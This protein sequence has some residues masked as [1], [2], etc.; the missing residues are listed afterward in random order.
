MKQRGMI[1]A[2]EAKNILGGTLILLVTIFMMAAVAVGTP[3]ESGLFYALI[4]ALVGGTI[5]GTEI[6]NF[7]RPGSPLKEIPDGEYTAV[8]DIISVGSRKMITINEFVFDGRIIGASI[9]EGDFLNQ[10]TLV[11]YNK[12]LEAREIK[13]GDKFRVN[14][15]FITK[16]PNDYDF[17]SSKN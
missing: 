17:T 9:G 6:K 14:G 16:L 3:L 1:E 13:N 4:G 10:T 5:I 2:K 7:P 8:S 11:D 15:G 12:K